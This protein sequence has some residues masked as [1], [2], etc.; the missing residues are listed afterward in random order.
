MSQGKRVKKPMPLLLLESEAADMLRVPLSTLRGWRYQGC[1]PNFV[2][3]G[4]VIIRYRPSAVREFIRDCEA[5]SA[6]TAP[7]NAAA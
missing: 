7:A 2:R 4:T 5:K 3:L 1:G 6:N